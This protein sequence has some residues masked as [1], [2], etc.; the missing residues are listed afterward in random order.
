MMFSCRKVYDPPNI[1][2][3]NHF[4]AVD[5]FIYTGT[6]VTSMIM[7]SRS[8][9]LDDSGPGIAETGAQVTIQSSNGD[10]YNLI[11]SSGSGIYISSALSLDSVNQYRLTITTSDGNKFQSDYVSTKQSPP[12][13][14]L[15]WELVYDP[16]TIQQAANIYIDSHDPTNST[17]YYRW[18]FLETYKHFSTLSTN[19]ADSDGMVYPLPVGYSIHTCWSTYP[20]QNIILGT[21]VTLSQDVISHLQIAGFQQ[22][23]PVLDVGCSFLVRQFP[24]TKEGYEY[25]LTVQKNSQSLGSLFDL[26]PS[27]ISGNLHCITNPANPVIGFI[28]ASTVQE[29]RIYIS[30]KS[31]PGWQSLHFDSTSCQIGFQEL[32]PLNTL[33]Y[34][35]P[36]TSYG[37]YFFYGTALYV[38]P[39]SC[40][41]CRYQGGTNIKPSFWPLYD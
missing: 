17:R 34:N 25:W 2:G 4:L 14:S 21:T 11:D 39:K 15:S 29:K 36:D 38:A 9:N 41:D 13:D 26:T 20:S 8:V 18:D 37:P 27:Q 40:L 3:K 33:L 6:T 1:K 10:S 35:Y 5:G 7:L 16:I 31:L 12:I 19:W 28:S 24:L 22:N 23:D 32:D 30:N